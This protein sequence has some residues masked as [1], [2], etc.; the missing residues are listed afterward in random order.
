MQDNIHKRPRRK[1]GS[2]DGMLTGKNT[3]GAMPHQLSGFKSTKPLGRPLTKA[4]LDDFKRSDGFH[5]VKQPTIEHTAQ[6]AAIGEQ[7]LGRQPNLTHPNAIDLTLDPAVK[8]KKRFY[9]RWTKKWRSWPKRKYLVMPAIVVLIAGFLVIKGI[10]RW[11]QIFQGGGGAAALQDNVDPSKLRGEGDGRINILLLGRGGPGHTAPDLTDTI[12]VASIDPINKKAALLSIPRDLWVQPDGYGFMK[13]N[14]VYANAKSAASYSGKKGKDVENAGLAAIDKTVEQKMGIPIHYHIM[15]D[16][17]AFKQAIDTVGGVDITVKPENT[18]YETLW[19]EATG[20]NYTLNVQTGEQH[21]DGTRALFYARSR[22]TSPR[23]DFDR[24]ERQRLLLL[25]LKSKV[26]SAGTLANPTK[27]SGLIDAFGTHVTANMTT[28][29][30]RRLFDIGKDINSDS[31]ASLGLADPPNNFVITGNV[32]GQSIVRPKAGLTDFTA[33]QSYVRNALRD[34]FIANEDA[35]ILILNGT[36]ITGLANTKAEELKS[37]G[38]NVLSVSTAPTQNYTQTIL[39]DLRSGSKKYT[40]YYLEKR[41]GITATTSLPD[42]KIN[43]G[44]ADFV[45][46]LGTK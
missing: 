13:I 42:S 26:L 41:L 1:A 31:V 21:F 19:D 25:A 23:G 18:V 34:G 46:I 10:W 12:L 40:K 22:Y 8:P 24:T 38:Y 28:S 45:I 4:R 15:V 36:T 14:A 32:N 5:P 20:R 27:L 39:I 2:V 43:P 35:K 30:I 37:Y 6:P 3:P 11:N 29:E 9:Q 44:T 33:I 7:P 17:K 16:F